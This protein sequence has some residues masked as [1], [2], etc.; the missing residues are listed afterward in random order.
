MYI[1]EDD[2]HFFSQNLL[3]MFYGYLLC[4]ELQKIMHNS[5]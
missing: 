1:L 2:G 4:D 3:D 5:S